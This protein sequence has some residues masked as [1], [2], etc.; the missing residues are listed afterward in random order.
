MTEFVQKQERLQALLAN[1]KLDALLLKRVSSFAW[2][3]SGASSYINTASTEGVGSLLVTKTGRYL[4]T[5]NIE[6]PRFEKEDQLAAQG[7]EIRGVPWHSSQDVIA[8]LTRGLK[9][10]ADVLHPGAVDV[11]AE[12]TGLRTNLLPVEVER[13][14][15]LGKLCAEAMDA[16][17]RAVK[18]GQS[19]HQ[20]AALLAGEA[21]RRGVQPIVNLIATDERIF[22]F[23]HPL[24]TAKVMDRY[25]MLVLCGRRTGLVCSITRLVH[26]GSLSDELRRKMN[27]VAQ[28]DAS[29]IA[30]TRPGKTLGQ[31]FDA[32]TASYAAVGFANE[33]NLHH[34]GGPAGYEPREIVA[35]PGATFPV[36]AGQTYAWN[37]SITGSKSEDTIL[38]TETGHEILSAVAGWPTISVNINGQTILRPATLEIA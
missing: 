30:T 13:F 35:T 25:A 11:S 5:T 15:I 38:V 23:R 31:V 10:G 24:P 4:I 16:A 17:I 26:F 7:W 2:A 22:S 12:M 27:A 9:V 20:I 3:T 34:Q 19:E 1:R 37:P 8:E 14:R 6:A 33:W 29:V 28:I 32:I 21:E 18:P 36:A